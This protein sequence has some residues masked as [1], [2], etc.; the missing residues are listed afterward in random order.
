[1]QSLKMVIILMKE[2]NLIVLLVWP[3]VFPATGIILSSD[4]AE[5]VEKNA[6]F[7]NSDNL[8]ELRKSQCTL[9]LLKVLL[10][11]DLI[12]LGN[13]EDKKLMRRMQSLKIVSILMKEVNPSVWWKAFSPVQT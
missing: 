3:K 12:F 4:M 6:E 2:A 1:M 5:V 7:E 13:L 11:T 9:S 8:K 10:A